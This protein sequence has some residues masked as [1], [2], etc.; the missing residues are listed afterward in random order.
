MA[1]CRWPE[2]ASSLD[3]AAVEYLAARVGARLRQLVPFL[4]NLINLFVIIWRHYCLLEPC[5]GCG[6]TARL[7]LA[8]NAAGWK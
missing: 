5:M 7:V 3:L 6:P 4:V 8:L 2:A 1:Q